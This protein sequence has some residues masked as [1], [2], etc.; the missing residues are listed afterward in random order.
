MLNTS[1]NI[2]DVQVIFNAQDRTFAFIGDVAGGSAASAS[3][4]IAPGIQVINLTLFTINNADGTQASF[5]FYPVSW[6]SSPNLQP[7][8]GLGEWFGPTHCHMVVV[9]SNCSVDRVPYDFIVTVMY[10]GAA[11]ASPDP[12]IINDPP[13][14]PPEE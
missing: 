2:Y 7:A 8:A 3:I 13:A 11:F 5:K 14:S 4:H 6:T 9:N 10:G 12:T 1:S